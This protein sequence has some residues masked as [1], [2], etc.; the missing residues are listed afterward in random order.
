MKEA[1]N[2]LLRKY[3]TNK[4]VEWKLDWLLRKTKNGEYRIT[5]KLDEK[6]YSEDLFRKQLYYYKKPFDEDYE[7]GIHEFEQLCDKLFQ[8]GLVEE[9]YHWLRYDLTLNGKAFIG[10]RKTKRRE[11]IKYY[12]NASQIALAIAVSILVI[13]HTSVQIWDRVSNDKDKKE[14][15]TE[16]L[17]GKLDKLLIQS[18]L[19][20]QDP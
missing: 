18:A 8:D 4:S 12:V 2:I 15:T 6:E 7:K 16:V 3:R 14:E 11:T 5:K 13:V 17:E 9:H 1:W 20:N 10:Y 19:E